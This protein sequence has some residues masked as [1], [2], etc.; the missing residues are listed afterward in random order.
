[1]IAFI[2]AWLAVAATF[3][4]LDFLWLGVIARKFYRSAAG[5]VLADSF[6]KAPAAVF[7]LIYVT[8]IVIFALAAPLFGV[9][10]AAAGGQGALF[11][12]FAYAAVN[13]TNASVLS[14]WPMRLAIVDTIWGTV[15]TGVSAAAGAWALVAAGG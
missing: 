13:F 15:L 11:G 6:G 10:V 14:A 12:F 2:A 3:L 8:G 9:G 1:M 7:Y 5:P 4:V